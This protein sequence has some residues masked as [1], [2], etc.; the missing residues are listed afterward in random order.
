MSRI[1]RGW[2]FRG[3]GVGGATGASGAATLAFVFVV[4]AD[5]WWRPG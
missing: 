4:I 1:V 2:S 5:P 3:L